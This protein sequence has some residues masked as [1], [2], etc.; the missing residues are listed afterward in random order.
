MQGTVI[1]SSGSV[2]GVRAIDGTVVDCRVKGN[3]RLKGIRSTNPVAVGDNVIFDMR[4]DGTAY[5][6]DILER[7]N[8]I[9]RKASNL[10]KQSHI[11]AANSSPVGFGIDKILV[12][13]FGEIP[14][15]TKLL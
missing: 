7:K 2:Y 9:V 15:T 6:V 5:I 11:L 1:K 3:F 4:E 12:T 10:S 14:R 8:Y 13:S